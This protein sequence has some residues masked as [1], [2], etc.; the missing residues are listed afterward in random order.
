M[1][2]LAILNTSIITSV[3]TYKL[4]NISLGCAKA[5][6]N[7]AESIDSAVGHQSTAEILSGLIGVDIPM[8]RQNF[9]QVVGQKAL[10]FKLKGRPPEGKILNRTE[11][12]EIGYTFQLLT[13]IE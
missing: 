12:E 4:E 10:V 11:I 13:R 2:A 6:V 5:E 3:G 1:S 8:N 7:A 9:A